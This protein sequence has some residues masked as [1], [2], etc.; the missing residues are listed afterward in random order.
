MH[1]AESGAQVASGAREMHRQS[2][3]HLG[4]GPMQLS[5]VTHLLLET[6][7]L[8]LQLTTLVHCLCLLTLQAAHLVNLALQLLLALHCQATHHHQE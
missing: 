7:H 5:S 6:S 8:L 1:G 2:F 3:A 4:S